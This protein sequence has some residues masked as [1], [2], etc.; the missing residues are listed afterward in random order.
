MSCSEFYIG[1]ILIGEVLT[2]SKVVAQML[3]GELTFQFNMV[4]IPPNTFPPNFMQ[5]DSNMTINR[6]LLTGAG[7]NLGRELRRHLKGRFAHIR[8]ADIVEMA[9]AETGEEIVQCDM[10]DRDGVLALAKDVDAVIHLGGQPVEADWETIINSNI[11][12]CTHMFEAAYQAGADRVLFASSNHAIGFHHRSTKIDD[13][14]EPRPDTRYGL[15]KAFCED[16]G[17]LYAFKH[18]LKS[19]HMRIG[20]CFLKPIDARMLST[21][22][23]YG[24]FCR[25]VDVGL[26]VD[27]LH[28]IVYGV[29]DNPASFWDN[30]NAERMGYKPLDTA[31]DYRDQ[32]A[33]IV[34]GYPVEEVLQGG[35]F[36]ANE[37]T[38]D[39]TKI[40]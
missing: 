31:E 16:L 32:V 21:W 29:S 33:G 25:L 23:S 5:K 18:G 8:L 7:G 10:A 26:E 39:L 15:S 9:P 24:D 30:G 28:E 38:F 1:P 36:P 34:S 35:G 14:C 40:L 6:I 3:Y 27:Y 2:L 11:L 22:L 12:G 20:S 17:R 13:K 37:F 4:D 19:F